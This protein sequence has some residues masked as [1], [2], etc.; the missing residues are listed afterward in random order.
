MCRF[1]RASYIE[2]ENTHVTEVLR[3]T[4]PRHLRN[5]VSILNC[6]IILSVVAVLLLLLLAAAAAAVVVVGMAHGL[7]IF[8]SGVHCCTHARASSCQQLQS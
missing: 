8:A 6:A 4:H 2:V 7:A 5:G 1:H 3:K